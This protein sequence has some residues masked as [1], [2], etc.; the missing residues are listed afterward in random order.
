M[1]RFKLPPTE[2]DERFFEN[3]VASALTGMLSNTN[4][5]FD[6]ELAVN[7]MYAAV[8]AYNLVKQNVILHGNEAVETFSSDDAPPPI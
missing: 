5:D 7:A 6:Q 8:R 3:L 4:F 2:T 1:T